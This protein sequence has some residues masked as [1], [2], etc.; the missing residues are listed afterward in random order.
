[1]SSDHQ[2]DDTV[3]VHSTL[4]FHEFEVLPKLKNQEDSDRKLPNL[5]LNLPYTV[6]NR[7]AAAT[8]LS[9]RDS[10]NQNNVK[11]I[12]QN[13]AAQMN[14]TLQPNNFSPGGY[15]PQ[16]QSQNFNSVLEYYPPNNQL[17][18]IPQILKKKK[19][20]KVARRRGASIFNKKPAKM[21]NLSPIRITSDNRRAGVN[22]SAPIQLGPISLRNKDQSKLAAIY[23]APIIKN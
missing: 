1:L 11:F 10:I 3:S 19:I 18:E 15:S 6:Q 7:N 16:H 21:H 12:N 5:E 4:R 22:I 9:E 8:F 13:S 14:Q 2:D 17:L 23:R 20:K